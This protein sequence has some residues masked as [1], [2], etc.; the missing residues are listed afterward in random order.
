MR[1]L[2]IQIPC[3]NEEKTLPAALADLPRSVAGYGKVEWLVID[4]GSSDRTI[5]VAAS[6]G[7]DHIV[8]LP[9]HAGLAKAFRSG[10]EAAL[11]AGA[12]TIVNTDADNQYSAKCIPALVAPILEGKAEMVI[13]ERPISD[14]EHF[15]IAKK[16][17]QKLG[18]WAVRVFSDTNIPDAPCGFRAIHKNAA[19]RLNVFTTYTYTLETIIQAGRSG[20]PVTSVP[21]EVNGP[22]RPSRLIK[23]IPRYIMLSVLVIGRIFIT[24]RPFRFFLM[25]GLLLAFPGI[26]FGLLFAVRYVRYGG[27]HIQALTLAAIF[28]MSAIM[29]FLI[30]ILSDI[31]AVNRRLSEEIRARLLLA[32]IRDASEK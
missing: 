10:I 23:S 6:H 15:S 9:H 21:I 31:V 1:K 14:I 28:M 19:V 12:D 4:D 3:Y 32:E 8:K 26:V 30:G 2:I 25:L 20:M 5:E 24:Y 11:K 27:V 18:S 29:S 7:V 13:G 16:M 17:L 22:M